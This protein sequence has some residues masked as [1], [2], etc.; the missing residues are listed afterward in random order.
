VRFRL[1]WLTGGA[2]AGLLF[3]RRRTRRPEAAL[4]PA[5]D[6]AAELRRKLDESRGLVGEREEFESAETAVD[7]ATAPGELGER[8]QRVHEKGRAAVDEMRGET[9]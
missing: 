6:P 2:L 3:F 7:E 8:R 1:A 4:E 5:F 9:R